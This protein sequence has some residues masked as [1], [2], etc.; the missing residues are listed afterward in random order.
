MPT[1]APGVASG[2]VLLF[3]RALG[4][5]GATS[6]LAGNIKGKTQTISIAIAS[7]VAVGNFD[8]AGFWVIVIM[9]FSFMVVVSV[10]VVFHLR[11]EACTEVY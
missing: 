6:M 5:Y 9:I 10:N 1:A 3:A 7:E 2:T 11:N 8:I 4:E